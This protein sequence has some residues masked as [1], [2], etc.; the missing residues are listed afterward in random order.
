MCFMGIFTGNTYINLMSLLLMASVLK[1]LSSGFSYTR[2]SLIR[3][4]K[5]TSMAWL[6]L[7]PG[8]QEVTLY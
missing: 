4:S 3:H 6:K 8:S 5:K 2:D 1:K 7:V